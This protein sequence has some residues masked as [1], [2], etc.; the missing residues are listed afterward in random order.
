MLRIITMMLCMI[1]GSLAVASAPDITFAARIVSF[2]P[3]AKTST[4]PQR[5]TCVGTLILDSVLITA[6]HCLPSTVQLLTIVCNKKQPWINETHAVVETQHHPEQDIALLRL[7]TASKCS[8]TAQTLTIAK[9]DNNQL[10]A[11]DHSKSGLYALDLLAAQQHTLIVSDP[12]CMTQGHSG[13]PV[14]SRD[15]EGASHLSAL[16]ISGTDECPSLQILTKLAPLR[17]WIVGFT[18]Q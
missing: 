12:L 18:T 2:T 7:H 1:S 15:K 5:M 16:L 17:Q 8:D 14:F 6:S 4:L 13:T 11:F 9:P 10:N 3:T